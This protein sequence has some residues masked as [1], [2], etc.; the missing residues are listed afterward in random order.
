MNKLK[1]PDLIEMINV[2]GEFK[3]RSISKG[4][5]GIKRNIRMEIYL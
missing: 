5:W 4:Y 3:Y 1:I 2:K